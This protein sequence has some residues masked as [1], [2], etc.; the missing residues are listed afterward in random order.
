MIQSSIAIGES[1]KRLKYNQQI[2]LTAN[3]KQFLDNL[4]NDCQSYGYKRT[5]DTVTPAEVLSTYPKE[6]S[7][8]FLKKHYQKI[9]YYGVSLVLKHLH[10]DYRKKSQEIILDVIKKCLQNKEKLPMCDGIETKA[11]LFD[12]TVLLGSYCNVPTLL[13]FKKVNCAYKRVADK[14][15]KMY[16]GQQNPLS[17]C[18]YGF[19]SRSEV[20]ELYKSYFGKNCKGMIWRKPKCL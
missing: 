2:S 15:C 1:F 10:R 3:E 18:P 11:S 6:L 8:L 20:N 12:L 9:C 19:S 7:I 14:E 5:S 16:K 4:K 17:D 13:A